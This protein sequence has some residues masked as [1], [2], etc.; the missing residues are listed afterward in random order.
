MFFKK[1]SVLKPPVTIL[2]KKQT[3]HMTSGF[4]ITILL[5]R[6]KRYHQKNSHITNGFLITIL[7]KGKTTNFIT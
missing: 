3:S 7:L 5:K 2:L 4:L 6:N 1:E